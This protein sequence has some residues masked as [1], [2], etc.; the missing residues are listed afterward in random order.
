MSAEDTVHLRRRAVGS[1]A[2][3][4]EFLRD[5]AMSRKTQ[6]RDLSAFDEVY[7]LADLPPGLEIDTI[8]ESGQALLEI[9]PVLFDPPPSLPSVVEGWISEQDLANSSLDAPLLN[10]EGPVPTGPSDPQPE[11][12]TVSLVA[13]PEVRRAYE[14]WLSLWKAWAEED[15]RRRLR[16]EWYIALSQVAHRLSQRDDEIEVV[17]GAG[18]LTWKAPSDAVIARHLLTTKLQA[19]SC[20]GVMRRG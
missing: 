14:E 19:L 20:F 4:V 8:A 6:I 13:A 2:A 3:L 7:W 16:R 15:G 11:P 10:G 18:L 17:L 12:G 1:T 5:L 9:D